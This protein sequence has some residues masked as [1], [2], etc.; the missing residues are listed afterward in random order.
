MFLSVTFVGTL[1]FTCV[2]TPCCFLH[3]MP[4][5]SKYSAIY[6]RFEGM[7]HIIID[8]RV[9]AAGTSAGFF[10]LSFRPACEFCWIKLKDRPDKSFSGT[11]S[12]FAGDK[13]WKIFCDASVTDATLEAACASISNISISGT[14]QIQITLM[15]AYRVAVCKEENMSQYYVHRHVQPKVLSLFLPKKCYFHLFSYLSLL[16]HVPRLFHC[17]L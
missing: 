13:T 5:V 1:P 9:R 2:F 15:D 4:V 7:L 6:S 8:T 16:L 17:S 12:K 10:H 14:V 3:L 11:L